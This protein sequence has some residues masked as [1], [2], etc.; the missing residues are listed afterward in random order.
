MQNHYGD[1]F[2]IIASI[3]DSTNGNEVKQIEILT[4]VN[5]PHNVFKEYL[6][7]LYQNGIIEYT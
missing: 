5:I 4:Q 7:F 3:L 6:L 2:D 1:K